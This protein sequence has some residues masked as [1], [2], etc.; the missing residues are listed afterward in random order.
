[1]KYSRQLLTTLVAC[2]LSGPVAATAPNGTPPLALAEHYHTQLDLPRYWVSE[3]YD[4]ARAWWNGSQFVSRGGNIY[5][6][7][8][9]F[10]AHLPAETLDGELW[11]GRGNFQLLMQTIRDHQPDENAW[12]Q[13]RFMAFD[14]P[15]VGGDFN[16]RQRRLAQIVDASP[17]PWLELVPQ[18]RVPSHAALQLLLEE[19]TSEGGEGLMLARDD[20]RYRTGRHQGLI[21]MKLHQDAEA[22][23]VSHQPGKGKYR[24]VM[25][26]LLVEDDTGRQFR[27]GTGFSDAQRAA[28]PPVGATVSYRY[29]GRTRSGKPRFARFLRVRP[30]E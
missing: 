12:R 26:S 14:M 4:G 29:Q 18:Q 13:V 3:K 6:A 23:V 1:M 2:V 21:K 10:T 20:S 19:V 16:Y 30:P 15:A 25:G 27:L 8:A 22:V 7:P 17:Q 11:M 5:H 24:N 28:P 9:W